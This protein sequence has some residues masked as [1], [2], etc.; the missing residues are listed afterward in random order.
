M[1]RMDFHQFRAD[2]DDLRRVIV[3]QHQRDQRSRRPVNGRRGKIT[4]IQSQQRFADGKEHRTSERTN[5]DLLPGDSD[6]GQEPVDQ[7]EDQSYR[8]KRNHSWEVAH[9]DVGDANRRIVSIKNSIYDRH[10][11]AEGHLCQQQDFEC[12]DQ[13][14][15]Q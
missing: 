10:H 7:R 8:D 4:E 2:Q 1:F 13:E 9:Q 12:D 6:I 14:E 11:R 5:P 15:C 3:P